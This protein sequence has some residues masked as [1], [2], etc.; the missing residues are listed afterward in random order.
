MMARS[1]YFVFLL[2]LKAQV[3]TYGHARGYDGPSDF[4]GVL[5]K[6]NNIS[7]PALKQHP[8]KRITP[9]HVFLSHHNL[10]LSRLAAVNK[11]NCICIEWLQNI[12]PV[13]D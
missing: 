11:Q 9:Q 2:L 13:N 12:V 5:S 6:Y 7:S 1:L 4:V 3:N 10:C 8:S